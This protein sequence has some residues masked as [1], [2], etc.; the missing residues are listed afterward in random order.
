[1]FSAC[2]I[3]G[4]FL[5]TN[6]TQ[7]ALSNHSQLYTPGNQWTTSTTGDH[8]TFYDTNVTSLDGTNMT[9]RV[10][11][12]SFSPEVIHPDSTI[13]LIIGSL[14]IEGHL[15]PCIIAKHIKVIASDFASSVP[16]VPA[17]FH[18]HFNCLGTVCGDATV[19][20]DK[21][22]VFPITINAY[23]LNDFKHFSVL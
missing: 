21:S 10:R 23:M 17:F 9:A 4:L 22:I 11:I 15:S 2:N 18:T 7:D 13:A 12:A 20:K 8:F 14:Y 5:L 19:L 3:S 16:P 1:M 6:G